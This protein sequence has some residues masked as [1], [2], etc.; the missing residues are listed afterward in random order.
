MPIS[1]ISMHQ[2]LSMTKSFLLWN[3]LESTWRLELAEFKVIHLIVFEPWNPHLKKYGACALDEYQS[4]T[5]NIKRLRILYL[6][7]LL[8]GQVD[9]W[10]TQLLV[11]V[12]RCGFISRLPNLLVTKILECCCCCIDCCLNSSIGNCILYDLVSIAVKNHKCLILVVAHFW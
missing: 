4:Q 5:L 1:S 6:V 7:V 12:D 3:Q 8:L 9:R 10:R 2:I 11:Q